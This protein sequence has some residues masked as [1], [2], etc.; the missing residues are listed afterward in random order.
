MKLPTGLIFGMDNT[1]PLAPYRERIIYPILIVAAICLTPLF[2]NSFIEQR[3]AGGASTMVVVIA[4]LIDAVAIRLGKLPPIPF[5]FLLL[6]IAVA[7]GVSLVV[8]GVFGAL[9]AYP[10]AMAC[11]FVLSRRTANISV[12]MLLTGITAMIY[13]YVGLNMAVRFGASFALTAAVANCILSVGGKLQSELM[14]QAIVDPLTGAFNR[15]HMD[16]RLAEVTEPGRRSA[17][18]AT[19]LLID[20]DHFK[21]I[22]DRLG[23]A[24][25]DIVLKKLVLLIDRHTR[26]TDQL[27]RMGGEEFLLLLPETAAAEAMLAAE[28]L[29]HAI[30]QAGWLDDYSQVTISVGVSQRTPEEKTNDWIRKADEPCTGQKSQGATM[31]FARAATYRPASPLPS[32]TN[33]MSGMSNRNL[34]FWGRLDIVAP[35][36]STLPKDGFKLAAFIPVGFF[37]PHFRSA[38]EKTRNRCRCGFPLSSR[39]PAHRP[40]FVNAS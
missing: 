21:R 30:E 36:S 24:S 28:N 16:R 11:F 7:M 2:I 26:K 35:V 31:W 39:S 1:D 5:A 38:Q 33:R 9:W 14:M 4:F 10:A 13:Y 29:R 37:C 17:S 23:H 15:R 40:G 12:G 25:G 32:F 3:H 34:L 22:N 6:P 18:A 8:Q 20:I 27:F 19:I